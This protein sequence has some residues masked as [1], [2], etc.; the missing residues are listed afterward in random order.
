MFK[1]FQS[2]LPENNSCLEQELKRNNI[3]NTNENLVVIFYLDIIRR[4]LLEFIK[5]RD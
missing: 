2:S 4:L 5:S 1:D 3:N